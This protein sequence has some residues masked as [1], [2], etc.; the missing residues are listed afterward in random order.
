MRNL[1]DT[2]AGMKPN[3]ALN[4]ILPSGLEVSEDSC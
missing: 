1:L 4:E 2:T 3:I